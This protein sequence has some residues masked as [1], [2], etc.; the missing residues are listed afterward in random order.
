MK[1]G[2]RLEPGGWKGYI[3]REK[4]VMAFMVAKEKEVQIFWKRLKAG[5]LL[6]CAGGGRVEILSPGTWNFEEGPDFR[7]AK[8][9]VGGELRKG[10]VEIHIKSSDWT[11]HGHS[12]DPRYRDVKIHA[13]LEDDA[14]DPVPS[15]I[16]VLLPADAKFAKSKTSQNMKFGAGECTKFFSSMDDNA[17]HRLLSE[18][19]VERFR[20]KA[21]GA[22]AE[23]IAS[24]FDNAL[25]RRIFEAVGYKKNKDNFIELF[26]RVSAHPE[27][28]GGKMVD[29]LIWGES[30]LLPDPTTRKVHP[31][32][33]AFACGLWGAWW[34]RREGDRPPIRWVK[35]GVRPLNSP[36]RRI[37]GL[38]AVISKSG[39]RIS[40]KIA[41]L[42]RSSRSP[43]KF[44]E[45]LLRLFT[46]SDPVWDSWTNFRDKRN[47]KAAVI[48]EMR[49]LDIA[50]N[51]VLPF[52]FAKFAMEN[53]CGGA[54]FC[55]DTYKISPRPQD[56]IRIETAAN[57]WFE[58]P[59]R[60]EA[61]IRDAASA[62]GAIYLMKKFCEGNSSYC[63]DCGLGKSLS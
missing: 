5:T 32:M 23:I 53:D 50:V 59:S 10:D 28:S 35:S 9:A 58:P 8:F 3:S 34:L 55:L 13:V 60:A 52:L 48:G 31:E 7:D 45:E 62:Q 46:A 30:G 14:A 42:K 49:A 61:V 54:D 63:P 41:A 11:A 27:F 44:T 37:A 29:A 21:R 56:N 20:E 6:D 15:A 39:V 38:C 2:N 36:E 18:A 16:T 40:A 24:G 12:S 19:G 22:T 25:L 47:V 4:Q 57:K 33:K 43:A 17:V 26:E 1:I 51:V